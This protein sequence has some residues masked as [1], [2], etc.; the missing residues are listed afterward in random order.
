M[1]D[2]LIIAQ[3]TITAKEARWTIRKGNDAQED[4]LQNVVGHCDRGKEELRWFVYVV[5]LRSD[6]R[7]RLTI[8]M[9]SFGLIGNSRRVSIDCVCNPAW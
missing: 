5:H 9:F 1:P 8:L 3:Q 6:P 7:G 4:C 2:D